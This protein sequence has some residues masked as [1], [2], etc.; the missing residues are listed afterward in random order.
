MWF[1]RASLCKYFN[2][3]AE[4]NS[5]RFGFNRVFSKIG[6]QYFIDKMKEELD[7][8]KTNRI[9]VMMKTALTEEIQVS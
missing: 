5:L 1:N 3:K 9:L 7:K 8:L 6:T 2:L 4:E